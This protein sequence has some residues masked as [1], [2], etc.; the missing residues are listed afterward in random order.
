MVEKEASAKDLEAV[1]KFVKAKTKDFKTSNL[2][3]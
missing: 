2:N 1:A 3:I